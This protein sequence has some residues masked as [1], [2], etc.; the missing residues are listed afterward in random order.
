MK[1]QTW[2]VEL[3]IKLEDGATP[4]SLLDGL[5]HNLCPDLDEELLGFRFTEIEE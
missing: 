1:T 5:V 3:K 4:Y 2:L